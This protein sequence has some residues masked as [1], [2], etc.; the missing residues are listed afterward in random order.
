MAASAALALPL[1]W[2][3][4]A[5]WSGADWALAPLVGALAIVVV[6]DLTTRRIP[7]AVTLPGLAYALATGWLLGRPP[8]GDALLGVVV[9]GGGLLLLAAATRGFGGGDV[10]LM[11]LL[12]AALGWHAALLTLALS[13]LVALVI[14]LALWATVGRPRR[15]PV[16]AVLALVGALLLVGR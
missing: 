11:G 2:V 5:R 12:G 3:A 6:L 8:L 9:A 15:L 13:Q 16:G 14:A 7:D 4:R 10:K 1:L